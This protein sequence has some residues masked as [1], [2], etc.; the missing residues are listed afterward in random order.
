LPDIKYGQVIKV[1]DGDTITIAT[2]LFN[3]DEVPH[4]ETYRFNIR[5]RGIN[6]PELRTKIIKKGNGD[7]VRDYL[8]SLVMDKIVR[9][10]NVGVEKEDC[11]ATC[12]SKTRIFT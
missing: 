9:L 11:C 1:Y 10:E 5:L 2:P 8:A 12:S 7:R 3:G 4:I 6:T